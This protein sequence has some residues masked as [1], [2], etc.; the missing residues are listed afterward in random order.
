MRNL[1]ISYG[2]G[3]DEELDAKIRTAIE[4]IG[5]EEV[6]SGSDGIDR[7]FLFEEKE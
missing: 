6:A 7:D 2:D 1:R 5:F 3:F 4:G